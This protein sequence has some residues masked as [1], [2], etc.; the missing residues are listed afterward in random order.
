MVRVPQLSLKNRDGMNELVLDGQHLIS[1]TV[2]QLR[3]VRGGW[4]TGVL[5]WYGEQDEP[6][7]RMLLDGGTSKDPLTVEFPLPP[8]AVVRLIPR[9]HQGD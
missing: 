3:L 8:T 2:V 5:I 4:V 1:G 6:T 9:D 7:F